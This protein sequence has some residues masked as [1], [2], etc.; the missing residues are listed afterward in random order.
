MTAQLEVQGLARSYGDFR[1]VEGLDFRVAPGEV[2]G[3]VGPN[4]AGKTTTLRCLAGIL[5]PTAGT[6]RICGK[7]VQREPVGAKQALAYLPDE[8]RLFEYLTV[9]EHLNFTARL[10]QV[11]DWEAEGRSLLETLELSGKESALP[12]ELSRGMKQKLSIACGFLHR[13]ALVLLDEPLTGLDPL[14]I[15]RMKEALRRRAVSGAAL[16]LSS[17]LLPLVEELCHRVLILAKGHQVAYGTVG[18]I[19]AQ[20]GAP[21]GSLED[22][23][24]AITGDGGDA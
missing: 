20:A 8:P 17:H 15:R 16:V 22:L 21:G 2:L 24:L 14:G 7:D 6:V 9:W 1:A 11:A 13:P 23:F 18:E 19:R 12:G 5:P 10:Y 3:L 4:G